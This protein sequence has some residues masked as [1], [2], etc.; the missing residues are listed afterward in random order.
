MAKQRYDEF[1][2]SQL[3]SGKPPLVLEGDTTWRREGGTRLKARWELRGGHPEFTFRLVFNLAVMAPASYGIGLHVEDD[4]QAV[5]LDVR[6]RHRQPGGALVRWTHLHDIRH[7]HRE[8]WA[9]E[10]PDPPFWRTRHSEVTPGEYFEHL[11][12]MCRYLGVSMARF[13]WRHPVLEDDRP[14]IPVP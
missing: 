10:P 6:G 14:L 4:N 12:E 3:V 1:A 7:G 11:Q 13:R 9:I 8:R 5:R 2:T